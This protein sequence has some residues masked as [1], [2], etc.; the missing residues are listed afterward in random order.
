MMQQIEKILNDPENYALLTIQGDVKEVVIG[1]PHHAPLGV[2]TLPCTE[3]PHSDENTGVIGYEV[4]RLL[5]C[6][7]VIACNSPIDPN[8]DKDSDYCKKILAWKPKF[9]VEIH[10]H[11]GKSARFDIEIS[12]GSATR[13]F[14]SREMAEKMRTRL[15]TK[16]QFQHY[17]VSGD[18]NQIY[19][20]AKKSYTITTDAW[21]PFHIELPWPI[22]KSQEKSSLFCEPLAETI[23]E[24]LLFS[25]EMQS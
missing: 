19:L 13:N 25:D 11:G 10:G 15:N 12:S 22:R 20:K 5:N 7:S 4:A 2:P 3:H 18:I 14:W 1:V 21:I 24:L 23:S 16:S 8:K 6:S 17:T 9:L